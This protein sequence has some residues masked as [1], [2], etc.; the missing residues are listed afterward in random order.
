F[1]GFV[2]AECDQRDYC[3]NH[4]CSDFAECKNTPTGFDCWCEGRSGPQCQLGYDPCSEEYMSCSGH[5]VCSRAGEHNI[6]FRCACDVGWEGE[7]CEV[8]RP[9]CVVA[10]ETNQTI[11]LNGGLC[12]DVNAERGSYICE[13]KLGW[14]G[15]YCEKKT[16]II[17]VSFCLK[18][19]TLA[20][21]C[22]V[23]HSWL[24]GGTPSLQLISSSKQF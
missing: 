16:T 5:G 7:R 18:I 17:Y 14:W 13:C 15:Q 20:I 23:V 2:G 21:L 4:N 10:N 1:K 12:K 8:R 11:C 9:V 19:Y 3:L 6:S 22:G 24:W